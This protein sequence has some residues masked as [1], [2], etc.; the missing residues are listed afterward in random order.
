MY[1][2]YGNTFFCLLK[3]VSGTPI[4]LKS[5]GYFDKNLFQRL[6]FILLIQV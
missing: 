5:V 2:K 4:R 3:T 6:V 1:L